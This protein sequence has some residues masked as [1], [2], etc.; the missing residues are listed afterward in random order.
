[1][2]IDID[3]LIEL[4]KKATPERWATYRD[5]LSVGKA[6]DHTGICEVWPRIDDR[7]FDNARLIAAAN[8]AVIL[9]LCERLR[10]AEK[11]IQNALSELKAG[12]VRSA[13]DQLEEGK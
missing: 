8:P 5:G 9:A 13:I 4:A 3:G 1:M 2:N 10:E 11:T 6:S 12:D 7:G